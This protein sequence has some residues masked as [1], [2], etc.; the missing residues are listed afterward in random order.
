MLNWSYPSSMVP[1][2]IDQ[3]QNL[4]WKRPCTFEAVPREVV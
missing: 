4:E 3:L 2:D 1:M